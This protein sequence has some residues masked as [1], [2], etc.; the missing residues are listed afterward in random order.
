MSVF[1][2]GATIESV[3][4]VVQPPGDLGVETLD[5]LSSLVDKSLLRRSEI[6]GESRFDMLSTIRQYADERLR[7]DGTVDDVALR[8]AE[9]LA[10]LSE[11][12]EAE[13]VGEDQAAW[14]DRFEREHDNVRAALRWS[15]G[16]GRPN[17]ACGSAPPSGGLEQRG[18]CR[19]A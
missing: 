16:S 12:A 5:G 18:I 1:R 14:Q 9:F 2:G 7:D 17:P 3:D 15:I 10:D 11:R 19:G 13:F 4:A 8:H 6:D